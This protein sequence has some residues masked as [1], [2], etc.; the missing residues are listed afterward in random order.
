MK[1]SQIQVEDSIKFHKEIA[2]YYQTRYKAQEYE[3]KEAVTTAQSNAALRDALKAQVGAKQARI[4]ALNERVADLEEV[5]GDLKRCVAHLSGEPEACTELAREDLMAIRERL[6]EAK[7]R[8]TQLIFTADQALASAKELAAERAL[9][10]AICMAE[11][12]SQIAFM[13]GHHACARCT[14]R[15]KTC[16]ICRKPVIEAYN[17]RIFL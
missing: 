2:V 1:Q 6:G 3:L 10:C 12:T 17:R 13:C 4:D 11:S 15:L 8:V 14:K 9:N 16:H 5:N 7:E